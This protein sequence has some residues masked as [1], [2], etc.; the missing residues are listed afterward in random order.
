LAQ[1]VDAMIVGMKKALKEY[2]TPQ[3][4]KMRL[5]CM[6]NDVSW[7]EPAAKYVDVFKVLMGSKA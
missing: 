1:G 3:F 2:G 7:K 5:A 6:A 4:E